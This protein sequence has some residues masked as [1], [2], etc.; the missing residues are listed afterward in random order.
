M[1]SLWKLSQQQEEESP[2]GNNEPP[3]LYD[4]NRW[5]QQD[6]AN[7]GGGDSGMRRT[8]EKKDDPPASWEMP[9][10]ICMLA[11]MFAVLITDRIGTDS[12]MLTAL[13]VFFL[14]NIINIEEALDGFRSKGLLTVLVLFVVAEGLNKTGALSWYVGKMLGTPRT[15][16]EAQLRLLLPIAA[17][18]GF[19]N[20]TPLVVM[21]LPIVIQWAKKVNISNRYLLMPL[22]FAALLGGV[23]TIIGTSTNLVIVGLLQKKYP[24]E[25]RF[26]NISLFAITQVRFDYR[27]G[28][29]A[30][31]RTQKRGTNVAVVLSL[32][33]FCVRHIMA[34]RSAGRLGRYC[35][36]CLCDPLAARASQTSSQR[37]GQW[38]QW[39]WRHW[40]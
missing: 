22:S 38:R 24:D 26:Q 39:Y 18:S 32:G 1:D 28:G 16:S 29:S 25:D 37:K 8:Q 12:V 7:D 2:W 27:C 31:A 17:L 9:F 20:D 3:L 4:D 23:G 40:W 34:V 21:T 11:L 10:T 35:L 14:S 30:G 33:F 6:A 13:T 36:H 15:P 5:L 19:I